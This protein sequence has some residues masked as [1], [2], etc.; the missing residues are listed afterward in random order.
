MN[1]S[2]KG[3]GNVITRVFDRQKTILVLVIFV[4]GVVATLINDKFITVKNITNIFQQVTVL[5]IVTMAQAMLIIM[6]CNDLSYGG[7]IG[8]VSC[9]VCTLAATTD[10][11]VVWVVLIGLSVGTACGLIN[12]IIVSYSGCIPLILTL[13]LQYLY[14]GLTLIIARGNILVANNK[15]AFFNEVSL[16]GL[17]LLLYVFAAVVVCTFVLLNYTRYGRRIVAVG[18]NQQNA[19]LS[20]I[21]YKRLKAINYAY[22]GLLVAIATTLLIARTNA[23]TASSGDG[24]SLRSMAAAIIG[25]VSFSGGKGT[26]GGAFLGC[27]L[28]GVIA[29]A[30]NVVGLSGYYQTAVLG[31]IIVVAVVFSNI[32]YIRK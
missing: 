21:K 2:H 30:M 8:L 12:G 29:N 9:T 11:G 19:Y 18:G 1:T 3:Q 31:V 23:V 28:M 16:F 20:G 26:I 6:G 15:L 14:Y 25:G 22:G 5:G 10:M 4:V 17:P 32:K 27:I 7:M 24:Y 13:G